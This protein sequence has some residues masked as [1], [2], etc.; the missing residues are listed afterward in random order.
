MS[1][2]RLSCSKPLY[3]ALN[4]SKLTVRAVQG[5]R[6]QRRVEEDLLHLGLVRARED[7]GGGLEPFRTGEPLL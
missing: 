1:D 5:G 4:C 6:V 2:P 7:A 3:T